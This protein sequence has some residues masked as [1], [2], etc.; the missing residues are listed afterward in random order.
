MLTV[1][2]QEVSNELESLK[3]RFGNL[4]EEQRVAYN[5]HAQEA[6]RLFGLK[7][8][9]ETLDSIYECEKILKDDPGIVNLK[10][11]CY[12]EFRDFVKAKEAFLHA[13]SLSGQNIGIEFNL[14]EIEFVLRNWAAA[15]ER[16][17]KL[18]GAVPDSPQGMHRMILFK[19]LLCNIKLS[20]SDSSTPEQKQKYEKEV[21]ELSNRFDF[22]DDSP[23]YYYANAALAYSANDDIEAEKWINRA[24]RIFSVATL[25][26]WQ[27]SLIEVGYIKSFYG[28]EK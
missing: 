25:S 21:E 27:D 1:N 17:K 4:P 15:L 5:E 20:E 12:I 13:Q 2:A 23:F 28:G 16:F 26:S 9:F 10:G 11:A 8:V 22:R 3:T 18:E 14:A 7:R 6:S 19:S 24:R